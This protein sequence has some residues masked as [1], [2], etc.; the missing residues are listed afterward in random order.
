MIVIFL[1]I[2]YSTVDS[3]YLEVRGSLL[4]TRD[5]RTSTYQIC[6]KEDKFCYLLLDFPVK[7][8]ARFS[9]QD[10]RLFE[11]SEVNIT[12]VD[13]FFTKWTTFDLLQD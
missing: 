13:C 10:K 3:R 12:G 2:F 5:I 8:G 9:L 1:N 6:R 7:T 4:N 11:I